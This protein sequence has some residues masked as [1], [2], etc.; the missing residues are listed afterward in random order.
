MPTSID[1]VASTFVTRDFLLLDAL[2]TMADW[3]ATTQVCDQS[4]SSPRHLADQ[5]W[6]NGIY[7]GVWSEFSFS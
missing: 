2:L 6:S 7:L 3:V 1:W 5:G 4:F